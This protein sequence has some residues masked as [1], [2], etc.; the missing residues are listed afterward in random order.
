MRSTVSV[1]R[2]PTGHVA[3]ASGCDA[4]TSTSRRSEP[5]LFARSPADRSADHSPAGGRQNT[6][7]ASSNDRQ[8][9]LPVDQQ[10]LQREVEIGPPAD[11]DVLQRA[12]HVE[13]PAGVDVQAERAQEPA[14]M[15]QV[16]ERKVTGSA[17]ASAILHRRSAEAAAD[18]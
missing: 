4:G 7:N 5:A 12:R 17:S 18:S 15:E 16:V 3:E 13:H 9:L 2:R 14:E 11:V 1:T 6:R 10:R 8:V